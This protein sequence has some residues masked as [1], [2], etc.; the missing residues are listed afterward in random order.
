LSFADTI[1][2]K[3][4]TIKIWFIKFTYQKW[5]K[6]GKYP[7]P[8]QVIDLQKPSMPQ[9]VS[10]PKKHSAPLLQ[11]FFVGGAG[12]TH[13]LECGGQ[14][15]IWGIVGS[16]TGGHFGSTSIAGKGK[17]RGRWWLQ[18]HCLKRVMQ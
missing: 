17:G 11:D 14:G 3:Y 10:L 2:V 4:Y 15:C 16:L 1:S 7:N 13:S 8:D 6:I 18:T 5:S 12:S 9:I